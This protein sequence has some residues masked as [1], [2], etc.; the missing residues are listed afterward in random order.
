MIKRPLKKISIEEIA[1]GLF[2]DGM[3]SQLDAGRLV[4]SAKLSKHHPLII[5]ARAELK[6]NL[7]AGEVLS[8]EILTQWFAEKNEFTYL[9][10][11]PLK[12]DIET[13]T[14]LLPK[15]F[16]KRIGVL[17]VEVT[18]G[19]VIFATAEP[20]HLDWLLDTSAAI[21]RDIS[22]VMA[23][24][25]KIDRYIQEF[26]DVRS[27]MSQIGES[28]A[29]LGDTQALDKMAGVLKSEFA[30]DDGSVA[31]VVDWIFQYAKTERA[32]DIHME[33]RDGFAQMRFRIDGN[34][35]V[36][37]KFEPSAF[38]P[39]LSRIKIMADMKV[40]EKRRPQDG[41]IKRNLGDGRLVE[42][43]LSTIP[44]HYGEKLVIRI[45]DTGLASKSFEDLGF[46]TEDIKTWE[47]L[48][49]S[50]YGLILVTGPTGSGKTTTLQTSLSRIAGPELNICT[51]EDPVELV[52]DNFAQMQV[53]GDIGLTFGNA[54][55]SFLRQDPDV[56]MV[57]EI[58]D[59]DAGDMAIQASLT[60][61]L[62]LSTL[63]T[64]SALASITR[65]LDLGVQSHLLSASLLGILA[66]R[67]VRV[68]CPHCKQKIPTPMDLWKIVVGPYKVNVP[69]TVFGPIGCRECKQTG[70]KGRIVVYEMVRINQDL[71][72]IIRPDVTLNE[73]ELK[74]RGKYLPLRLN[75][76]QKV[77]QGKTGLE[78]IIKVII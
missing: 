14:R 24:P 4:K 39:I 56:I 64:N 52:N 42:M 34:L 27:A 67:L 28:D 49:G 65:L 1:R 32:T 53:H 58:R 60:G 41:R 59:Q 54:I 19:K 12:L 25:E 78:E 33:P 9:D 40:D 2:E 66:Q 37:Y 63:H 46:T 30:V 6:N 48:I 70:Y 76:L 21:K 38:I 68:L 3:I 47:G 5:A 15:A 45:F 26:Y 77:L 72:D 18:P 8:S 13:I 10:I 44:T 75:A 36:V 73:L 50:N 62:V 61:H 69:E 29:D 16:I 20:F 57:G 11:D 17:P 51:V 35:R 74:M 71:K 23:N 43:R 7:R 22:V 55:R 31:K